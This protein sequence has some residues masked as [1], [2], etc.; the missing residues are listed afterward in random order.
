MVVALILVALVVGTS[1]FIFHFYEDVLPVEGGDVGGSELMSELVSALTAARGEEAGRGCTAD[2][3][4]DRWGS[5]ARE[6]LQT[7]RAGPPVPTKSLVKSCLE[8]EG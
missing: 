4:A 1:I 6:G 8:V 5:Q 7:K 3:A 2:V